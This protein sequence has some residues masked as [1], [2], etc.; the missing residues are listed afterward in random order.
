MYCPCCHLVGVVHNM[1][2][3]H[4]PDATCRRK[5][6]PNLLA[7]RMH[8]LLILDR[9]FQ[10]VQTETEVGEYDDMLMNLT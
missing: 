10:T 9:L 5:S 2:L 7:K 3:I 8:V 6:E 4:C 1:P